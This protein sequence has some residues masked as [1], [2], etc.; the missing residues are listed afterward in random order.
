MRPQ[1]VREFRVQATAV[2]ALARSNA[3]RLP[4]SM[5]TAATELET[6]F[7]RP[8]APYTFELVVARTTRLTHVGVAAFDAPDDVHVIVP[9]TLFA[10]LSLVDDELVSLRL[11]ELPRARRLVLRPVAG[12]GGGGGAVDAVALA[13]YR[14]ATLGDT[15]TVGAREFTVVDVE[16]ATFNAVRLDA[17]DD[18]LDVDVESAA[19]PSPQRKRQRFFAVGRANAARAA[20]SAALRGAFGAAECVR[21]AAGDAE[22][23]VPLELVARPYLLAGPPPLER[24]AFLLNWYRVRYADRGRAPA[25]IS[26]VRDAL[27]EL[28]VLA[29]SPRSTDVR[30]IV[31]GTRCPTCFNALLA[32]PG[33]D[34]RVLRR[35]APARVRASDAATEALEDAD[36]DDT[37]SEL[38]YLAAFALH[39]VVDDDA[40]LADAALLGADRLDG[41]RFP[42]TGS[43]VA[44]VNVQHL[45][46]WLVV[47][48]NA[49]TAT[50]A[51]DTEPAFATRVRALEYTRQASAR[52]TLEFSALPEQ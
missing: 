2:D 16:P 40:G 42:A 28:D 6:E 47:V 26:E 3:L 5:L 9:A 50:E 1:L 52:T 31:R 4:P 25:V 45:E 7:G 18:S 49:F 51:D 48:L 46:C 12:G 43:T 27:P 13:R 44:S 38:G 20:T 10:A 33:E 22:M 30:E 24:P 37:T 39:R 19:P 34:Y 36:A 32:P 14:S 29:L 23:R 41:I 17:N 35:A 8:V 11:V 15:L 21:S